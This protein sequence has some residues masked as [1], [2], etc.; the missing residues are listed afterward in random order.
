MR[1]PEGEP[2]RAQSA[3]SGE[4]PHSPGQ[5]HSARSRPGTAGPT[6]LGLS[7]FRRS[8]KWSFNGRRPLTPDTLGPGPGAYRPLNLESVSSRF[9]TSPRFG[10]GNS[11][12]EA[13]DKRRV[14][15]PGT[16]TD[17]HGCIGD[18]SA[19]FSLTPRRQDKMKNLEMPG[20]GNH[21]IK[22]TIGQGPKYSASS[23]WRERATHGPGPGEYNQEDTA[24]VAGKPRWG[25]GTS[26]RPNTT[27]N[28]NS[29]TPGPGA[30]LMP[31]SVGKGPKYSMQSRRSDTRPSC[32]PGPGAH[33][34]HYSTFG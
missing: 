16:Y 21:D 12:R 19:K 25:F 8:P 2:R 18:G 34:G 23:R 28:V 24:V 13:H 14:P 32:S 4:R 31:P 11:S 1:S 22:C 29:I 9:N 15:G 5:R 26:E 10:F 20:P 27:L 33:G 3:P 7:H 17:Q 30:Y 6:V